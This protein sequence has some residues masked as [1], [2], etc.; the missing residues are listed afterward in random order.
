MEIA[1][2]VSDYSVLGTVSCFSVIPNQQVVAEGSA[3]ISNPCKP[4][5]FHSALYFPHLLSGENCA[6]S[7]LVK[8]LSFVP[9]HV[10]W[11][12]GYGP[13]SVESEDSPDEGT[14]PPKAGPPPSADE[15]RTG[16]SSRKRPATTPAAADSD[17]SACASRASGSA[18]NSAKDTAAGEPSKPV[19][20]IQPGCLEQ[21]AC[22][23][24]LL[25]PL[26]E[27]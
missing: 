20:P 14:P 5:H 24:I 21:A 7:K 10:G 25:Q 27:F 19:E 18:S 22:L 6:D 15:T 26:Q 9:Q 11:L 23:V 12:A 13:E 8:C 3:T 1:R 4:L 16:S 17:S 2:P